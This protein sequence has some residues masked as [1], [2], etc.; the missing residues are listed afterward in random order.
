LTMRCAN[1]I[2]EKCVLTKRTQFRT[3]RAGDVDLINQLE[4]YKPF[5]RSGEKGQSSS[6]VEYVARITPEDHLKAVLFYEGPGAQSV[7]Y[8]WP[9]NLPNTV[10]TV[11]SLSALV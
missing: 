10:L 9:H 8:C 3:I 5:G 7:G 2:L 4:R 1:R 11:F 6:V